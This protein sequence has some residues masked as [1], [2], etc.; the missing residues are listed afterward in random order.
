MICRYGVLAVTSV[1]RIVCLFGC[2]T[3]H[4][5]KYAK[6]DKHTHKVICSTSLLSLV[7]GIDLN[8]FRACRDRLFMHYTHISTR[9]LPRLARPHD[10]SLEYYSNRCTT[11]SLTYTTCT[12][13]HTIDTQ[14]L[15]QNASQPVVRL[16]QPGTWLLE[17]TTY[18]TGK[19]T[20]KLITYNRQMRLSVCVRV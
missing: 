19:N 11:H 6:C 5:W 20:R 9:K 18:N 17:N 4:F 8:W 15:M 13:T 16:C 3:S 1:I 7:E 2:S 14:V 10:D 12:C